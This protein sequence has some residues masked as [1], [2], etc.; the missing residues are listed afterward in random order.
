VRQPR[1]LLGLLRPR[2]ERPR[3]RCAADER[4]ELAP[5]LI[6]LHRIP[7]DERGPPRRIPNWQRS[8]SGCRN[9]FATRY[10]ATRPRH[11]GER[12]LGGDPFTVQTLQTSAAVAWSSVSTAS[13]VIT[14]RLNPSTQA[15]IAHASG[16]FATRIFSCSR[17]K[18][19]AGVSLPALRR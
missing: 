8:V 4:Y 19:M 1:D 6:E 2:R 13:G 3:C 12:L 18:H 9:D 11:S 10:A 16:L 7:H 5:F 17:C 15:D 14:L